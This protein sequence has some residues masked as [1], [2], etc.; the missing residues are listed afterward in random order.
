ML[1]KIEKLWQQ[2]YGEEKEYLNKLKELLDK[3]KDE[4]DYQPENENWHQ[5]GIVYSLYVDL[6]ADDFQGLI[7][8]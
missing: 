7:D 4:V 3:R 1:T 5:E 2:L 8:K 6:F